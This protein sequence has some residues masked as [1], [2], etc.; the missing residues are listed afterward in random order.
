MCSIIKS[1]VSILPGVLGDKCYVPPVI[2]DTVITTHYTR[3]DTLQHKN[4]INNTGCFRANEIMFLHMHTFQRALVY[5]FALCACVCKILM[6]LIGL[7]LVHGK[8]DH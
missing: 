6:I 3:M 1:V 5:I 4:G 8:A 7:G 2:I